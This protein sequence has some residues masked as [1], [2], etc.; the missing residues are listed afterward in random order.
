M[1][2]IAKF[3]SYNVYVIEIYFNK[4]VYYFNSY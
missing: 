1:D 3:S 2:N 4:N